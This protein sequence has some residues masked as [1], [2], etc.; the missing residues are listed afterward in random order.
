MSTSSGDIEQAAGRDDLN[1]Q[2]L[3][4]LASKLAA[5]DTDEELLAAASGTLSGRIL[6]SYFAHLDK[7]ALDGRQKD[8]KARA[9]T[10]YLAL[11][12]AQLDG[13]N[14]EI[15]WH[16]DQI[17]ALQREINDLEDFSELIRSG[18]YDPTNPEHVAR[19]DRLGLTE[20]DI[21]EGRAQQIIDD[22]VADKRTAIDAHRDAVEGLT[23]R[24]DRTQAALDDLQEAELTGDA[25][26]LAEA[27]SDVVENN[28]KTVVE[29]TRA[30][31]TSRETLEALDVAEGFDEATVSELRALRER[32]AA[33]ENSET[34]TLSENS[35]KEG[36]VHLSASPL[37]S[38]IDLN[39]MPLVTSVA[40]SLDSEAEGR[41]SIKPEFTEKSALRSFDTAA[42]KLD[43]E[44]KTE[45]TA[46]IGKPGS[47][48]A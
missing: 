9:E 22:K 43:D 20:R 25:A 23:E 35:E 21:Q 33:A 3:R 7:K 32:A 27:A 29:T 28:D 34:S 40:Q 42:I 26:K 45:I 46:E 31:T 24:R 47:G 2:E 44:L 15:D 14:A 18:K 11:L 41:L 36:A 37:D 30:E 38:K 4:N 12:Q 10:H 39:Q 19:R 48:L 13:L 1:P 6:V 5:Q 17:E 16:N 8:A